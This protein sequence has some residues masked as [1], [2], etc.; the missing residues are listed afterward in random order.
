MRRYLFAACATL[1][2]S[3][4]FAT[5]MAMVRPANCTN[6]ALVTMN[7]SNCVDSNGVGGSCMFSYGCKPM[8]AY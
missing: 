4:K 2:R 8:S 3:G 7:T 5:T 1:D 6:F